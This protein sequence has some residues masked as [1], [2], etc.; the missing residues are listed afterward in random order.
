MPEHQYLGPLVTGGDLHSEIRKRRNKN[1]YKTVTAANKNLIS[2]KVKLEEEDGWHVV[3][4]NIKSTRMA[5]PK[6]TDEQLEDEIWII[7]GQ[8]GFKEMST[9]RQFTIAVEDGLPHRQ[10]DVFAKDDESIVIVEC[11]QQDIPC[12]RSMANL[13]EK[14]GSIQT[15]L[16]RSISKA[17]GKQV[18]LKIKFVIAT[19]NISWSDVDLAKCDEAKIA[20]ITDGEID[21]YAALVRHL[22]HAARYQFL[23]HMFGGQKIQGLTRE[24]VATKG[25]MGG[26]PFYTFL[27][28]PDELLKIA[29]VGHKASRDIENLE[30]YQR[31]LQPQRLKKIAEYINAGGK[32]PTN[33]IMNF[34]TSKKS[35]LKF[36]AKETFGE[37]VLG[38]LYLPPIYASAWIID[39]QHRLYGYAYAREMEGFNQDK[40]VIPVLA[41]ENLPADKEMNLFIDINSKQ[42]K[43]S[44]GL[45]DELYSDLHWKSDDSE[46]AFQ[47]L[48][49][50]VASRL[51]STKSSPLYDRM[52]VTGKKKTTY[53]CLTPKSVSEGL[54]VARLL[55]RVNQGSIVPGPFSTTQKSDYDAHLMKSFSVV[56]DC[57][58]MFKDQVAD[59]WNAGDDRQVGYIC[60]NNGIRALFHVFKDISD[61]V[62][63]EQGIDFCALS[64][65]DTFQE[66]RPYIEALVDFLGTA[67]DHDVQ[68][69]RR[70]GSSLTAVRQQAFGM[71]AQIQ[72][73]FGDFNP[74]GLAEYVD[75]RDEAGTEDARGKVLRIQKQIFDY[76]IDTL[77]QA[78]GSEGR[79]WWVKGIPSKI[80]V[81]CSAR[82]ESKDQEGTPESH[83]YLQNY[84]DICIHNWDLVKDV[85]SLDANDKEAKRANT[86]WIRDLNGI[87]NKVA[88]PEQGVLDAGQVKLVKDTYEK[89]QRFFPPDNSQ[90]QDL[91]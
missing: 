77:Q 12:K 67:S 9:G 83:L 62:Q 65:D 3:R 79:K 85:I 1:V 66:I 47:A 68:A 32:F 30:T 90:A 86:K 84:V 27:V 57:L 13:I 39:G 75:S 34:R 81:D 8:M 4:K 78:Y 73:R 18:K 41:Y 89:V 53:R 25:K 80:R 63:E 91:A 48:C 44:A 87:R 64:S 29:Y 23:G 72:M 49:S 52:A 35:S 14:I 40:T 55:G 45:L 37:E 2:A 20:V 5:K 60:T 22:K 36:E 6:P 38:V 33:I 16:R 69:F 17:Y 71:E 82:W 10:I 59:R 61:H 56:S 43:V 21:Y 11:M 28:H 74:T 76:V 70:I 58:Q 7:L 42:T 50:R 51:N 19:R 31:M 46:E 24:V 54:K 88:H 15:I 26:F